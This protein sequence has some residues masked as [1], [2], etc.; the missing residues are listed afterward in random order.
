VALV[1]TNILEEHITSFI[2]AKRISE[3]RTLAV[4]RA[5]WHHI[6]EDSILHSHCCENLR[7]NINA[8]IKHSS[9]SHKM[10]DIGTVTHLDVL[11]YSIEK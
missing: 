6:P 3:L 8:V 9:R 11:K 1:R 7:S 2:R 10:G 5:T 4:T